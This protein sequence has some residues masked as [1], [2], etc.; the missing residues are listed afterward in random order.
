MN[1]QLEMPVYKCHKKVWALKIA[2]IEYDHDKAEQENRD[3]D[4]SAI[5]IPEDK[6]YTSFKID[7]WYVRKHGPQ[8]GGYYVVYN[9]G[10]K[11]FSPA[12]EFEDGYTLIASL[13]TDQGRGSQ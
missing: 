5:I 3:T 8:I 7:R 13:L 1:A 12:K 11:S 4:G 2:D 6:R 10:Y 9:D